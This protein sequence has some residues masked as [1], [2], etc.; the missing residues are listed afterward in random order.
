MAAA[1]AATGAAALATLRAVFVA[2]AC[3]GLALADFEADFEADFAALAGAVFVEAAPASWRGAVARASAAR[4]GSSGAKNVIELAK[5]SASGSRSGGRAGA[6]AH[7]A[8]RCSGTG[9]APPPPGPQ[10]PA[11]RTPQCVPHT[12]PDLHLPSAPVRAGPG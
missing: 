8:R 4:G 12:C 5:V 11:C 9:T 6:G 3:A 10:A 1:A 7:S 2:F